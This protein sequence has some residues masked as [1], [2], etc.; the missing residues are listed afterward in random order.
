MGVYYSV[1]EI[2]LISDDHSNMGDI[3]YHESM[4]RIKKGMS[5][6]KKKQTLIHEILHACFYEAGI[7]NQEEE[8]IESHAIVVANQL[9]IV[10]NGGDLMRNA[11]VLFLW[12]LKGYRLL[13]I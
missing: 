8:V 7:Q 3:L 12:V 4:I 2:D 1:N 5:K 9:N 13:K 10:V 6:D 11:M